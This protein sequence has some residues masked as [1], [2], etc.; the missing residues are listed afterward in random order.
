MENHRYRPEVTEALEGKVGRSRRFS[1]TVEQNMLYV[2]LP[3]ESSGR[4]IGVLRLSYFMKT[5]D[6][7]LGRLADDDRAD[8]P[9]RRRSPPWSWPSSCPSGSPG[10][11]AA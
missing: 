8:R 6:V 5:I 11:S 3:I 7:L 1:Y 4:T 2:G 10:R 9:D